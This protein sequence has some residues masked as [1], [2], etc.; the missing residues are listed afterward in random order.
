MPMSTILAA[1]LRGVANRRNP[2]AVAAAKAELLP[3]LAQQLHEDS[4]AAMEAVAFVGHPS[5]YRLGLTPVE[6]VEL[7]SDVLGDLAQLNLEQ[8][9]AAMRPSSFTVGGRSF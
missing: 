4:A 2:E 3:A 1:N 6:A 9:R 7:A 8:T 5:P